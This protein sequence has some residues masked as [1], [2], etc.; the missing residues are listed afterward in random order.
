MRLVVIVAEHTLEEAK[1]AN[2]QLAG[3]FFREFIAPIAKTYREQVDLEGVLAAGGKGN[4]KRWTVMNTW[5]K[6]VDEGGA[7]GQFA[8]RGGGSSGSSDGG[9]A[10]EE[11]EE[12]EEEPPS[13]RAKGKGKAKAKGKK[14]IV[15]DDDVI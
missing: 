7:S 11:A 4:L 9:G 10:E 1:Y 14:V 8:S 13:K 2:I 3:N 12:E 6:A 15:D 5:R